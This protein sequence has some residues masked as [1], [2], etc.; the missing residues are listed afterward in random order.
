MHFKLTKLKQTV[1]V[2]WKIVKA[3]T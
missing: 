3:V 1:P 2:G